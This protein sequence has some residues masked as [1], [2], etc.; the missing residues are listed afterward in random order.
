MKCLTKLLY[1][2]IILNKPV[3]TN[4]IYVTRNN[5]EFE[6]KV[7]SFWNA[8]LR[9]RIHHFDELHLRTKII[10]MWNK[11]QWMNLKI[12]WFSSTVRVDGIFFL[13]KTLANN[14]NLHW[15]LY[16]EYSVAPNQRKFHRAVLRSEERWVLYLHDEAQILRIPRI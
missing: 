3:F 2:Y 12:I 15:R 5:N 10:I 4:N 13:H 6:D 7:I 9:S 8:W 14:S 16:E 11:K 1:I